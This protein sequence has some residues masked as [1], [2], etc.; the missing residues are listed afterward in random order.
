M[1]NCI[2]QLH[3]PTEVIGSLIFEIPMMLKISNIFG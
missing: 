3:H 2:A 1:R